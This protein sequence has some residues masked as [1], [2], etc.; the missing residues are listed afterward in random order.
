[1]IRFTRGDTFSVAGTLAP[2][3]NGQPVA[4][5]AGWSA[6]A[7][8]M[9]EGEVVA[10][11]SDILQSGNS[12]VVIRFDSTE[13]W[14]LGMLTLKIRVVSPDGVRRSA[15]PVPFICAP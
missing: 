4:N 12:A 3:V 1:M 13:S 11:A 2:M 7:S 5:L 15:R 6:D 14:P 10:T 8:V 9:H